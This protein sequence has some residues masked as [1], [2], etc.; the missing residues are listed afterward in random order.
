MGL[1]SAR[2]ASLSPDLGS[3]RGQQRP[4]RLL[5]ERSL[6][7]VPDLDQGDIREPCRPVFL[8]RF[9]DGIQIRT[10][11]NRRRDMLGT[12]EFG[13]RRKSRRGRQVRI[14]GPPSCEPTELL[15]RTREG[16]IPVGIPTHR[17]LADDTAFRQYTG[18][19]PEFMPP[20]DDSGIRCGVDQMIGQSFPTTCSLRFSPLPKPNVKRRSA[21]ICTVAACWAT[22]AGWYLMLGQ[23]T[24]E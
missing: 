3:Q 12:D 7:S 1:E 14:D 2:S 15:V 6:V 21:R 22:T 24:Y 4:G 23:I 10:A 17:N 5:Q 20:F 16:R 19:M 11:R 8:H 18:G 13:G 9:D